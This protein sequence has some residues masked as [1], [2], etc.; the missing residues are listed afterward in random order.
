MSI[1]SDAP[2]T[3]E[4]P[5]ISHIAATHT[6]FAPIGT[7]TSTIVGTPAAPGEVIVL[8]GNGFGATTPAAV[9][10]QVQAGPAPMAVNPTITFNG[11]RADVVFAGLSATGL[12]Q[13]N[14][15]VPTGLPDG[16][17][18]VVATANGVT[19]PAGALIAIKN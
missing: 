4:R 5:Y 12:Y 17:A 14:V 9:N 13:F 16:D 1:R 3:H 10:G 6:S 15:T 18:A 7:A 8:Y 2:T 19:T 11:V